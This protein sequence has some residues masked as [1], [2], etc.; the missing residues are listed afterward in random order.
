M[1]GWSRSPLPE[2]HRRG[3][4]ARAAAGRR[5][6]ERA[7]QPLGP[8]PGDA[9]DRLGGADQGQAPRART[10]RARTSVESP[11]RVHRDHVVGPEGSA[12]RR[13]GRPGP[14]QR[15]RGQVDA[16]AV[17]AVDGED[18]QLERRCRASSS[19]RGRSLTGPW[20]SGAV[21]PA[22]HVMVTGH[23][24]TRWIP[25]RRADA[26][27]SPRRDC[28]SPE[29]VRVAWRRRRRLIGRSAQGQ[30]SA[31]RRRPGPRQA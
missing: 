9:P 31:R 5:V 24:P 19:E 21:V 1:D 7:Q 14:D 4:G 3:V 25:D 15:S 30:A 12:R 20:K 6:H 16:G 23:G 29:L 18:Q 28:R 22:Q 11:S 2:R 17:L 13:C 10:G 26:G 8:P 27:R